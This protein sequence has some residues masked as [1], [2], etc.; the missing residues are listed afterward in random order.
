MRVR[1]KFAGLTVALT[2]LLA[3]VRPAFAVSKEIVQLQTQ[4]QTLSD[5][6]AR[7]QQSLD[8]RMGVLRNLVEQST[9]SVNKMGATVNELQQKSQSQSADNASRLEQVS[10][11]VQSLHDTVDELKARLAK[12]SK[13]LD[14]MQ[15]S[16]QNIAAVQPGTPGVAGA[17]AAGNAGAPSAPPP[18][19]L[20]NNALRD[21]NAGKYDLSSQEFNDYIKNYGNTD[22]AG[23]A[24]FY[25]ADIEYRQGNFDAAVKDYDKVLEEYPGSTKVPPA[26]L[27][28]GYALLE[29]GQREAGVRELNSLIARYPRSVEAAQARDRL[30][31]LGVSTA[32]PPPA[33]RKPHS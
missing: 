2:L 21:Y 31:R 25:M 16:G 28:K 26:Q 17:P 32:A 23:D 6:V 10:G 27:K 18:E 1:S 20:Y 12:I 13:Q 8:E 5:Q 15:Q 7:M 14:D 19:T 22:R 3:S 4:V 24:Q 11:Q 30:K 29:L 9:D 33:A